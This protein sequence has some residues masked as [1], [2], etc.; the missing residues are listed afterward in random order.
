MSGSRSLRLAVLGCGRAAVLAGRALRGVPGVSC[1]FASRDP[2]RAVRLARR[3]GGPAFESYEAALAAPDVDA[4][5]VAT[6]PASHFP[7]AMRALECGKHVILEK[8]PTLRVC[9][10]DALRWGARDDGVSEHVARADD[11][12]AHRGEV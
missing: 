10:F 7:L 6:P 8:P 9:E 4:V 3:L 5:L 11:V 2:E 1:G 12:D